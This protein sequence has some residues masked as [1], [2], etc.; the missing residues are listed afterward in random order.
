MSQNRNLN[1]QTSISSRDDRALLA[2]VARS[3]YLDDLSRIEIA[4]TLG[5]SRFK[6]ARL[7]ARAR[8]EGVVTIEVN[9]RGLPDA[10]LSTRLRDTLGLERCTVVRSHGDD[11]AVRLQIGGAAASL[12]SETLRADEVLGVS[13]GRTL[14]ATTAQLQQLPR[15]SIVQLTGVVAGDLS[16]SPVE[17]ARQTSARSGGDVYPIFAPLF[18]DDLE[19]ANGLSRHPA[20]RAAL[21]LFP[22]VTTAI[23]SVGSWN[24]AESQVKD[25][26]PIDA[27]ARALAGG[28]VADIAGI[29]IKNDGTPVDAELQARCINISYEQLRN[30]PRVIAVAGGAAKAEAV[31]AVARGKLITELVTDHPLAEA[32]LARDEA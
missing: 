19:T 22:A 1:A 6:V 4:E 12:L 15:V 30:V 31:A 14:T 26:L 9:D 20:I 18:V 23:L 2:T 5:I 32:I 27:L 13:W 11:D 7:L 24:P 10:A 16:S 29:L 28:C 8:D 25:V 3:Y 21:D 17:V